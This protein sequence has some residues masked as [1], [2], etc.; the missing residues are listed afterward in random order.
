MLPSRKE[1]EGLLKEAEKCNPGPWGDHSRVTAYCAEKIA[2]NCDDLNPEKAYI[3][4]LL[5][6]IGRKFGVRHLGHVVDGYQYMMALG[7][8]EAARVCLSHS[9]QNKSLDDYVG[10]KDVSGDELR[11][12]LS[13]MEQMVYDDYDRLIQLCDSLSGS[14][15]VLDMEERMNDVQR[16][17]GFYPSEKRSGNHRL[18]HYFEEKTGGDIYNIVEKDTF[19]LR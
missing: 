13:Q 11:L 1:A 4:G 2:Q 10:N 5:H 9:F 7:Y 6:D 19:R 18:K 16:R 8:D 14:E 15:G 17:Y 3:V 12:I